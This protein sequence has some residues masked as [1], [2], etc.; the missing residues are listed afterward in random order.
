MTPPRFVFVGGLHR[1]GTSLVFRLLRAQPGVSGFR[2]T[3][4]WEDEGQHLQSLLP[5]ARSIG[6]PGRFGWHPDAHLTEACRFARPG[7]RAELIASWSPYW[8][9]DEK[10]LLEKSPPNLLR[11][12]LLQELF[13]EAAF[14]AVVRHPLAVAL[15]TRRMTASLRLLGVRSLVL[16]WIRCHEILEADRPRLRRLHVLRYEDLAAD[17]Q[18]CLDGLLR[19][20]HLP[21]SPLP[22]QVDACCNLRWERRWRSILHPRWL[23]ARLADLDGPVRAHGYSLLGFGAS[24]ERRAG[25][26][27]RG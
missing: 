24:G 2:G 19:F 7:A 6:G 13:P 11:F 10:V 21:T 3:G 18:G 16:H 4:V 20:L 9:M 8:D 1:S 15:S 17:P 25:G 27:A 5:A 23:R 14:V 26:D 22:E 12:R